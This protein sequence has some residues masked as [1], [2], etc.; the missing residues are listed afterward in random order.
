MIRIRYTHFPDGTHVRV[1]QDHHRTIVQLRAGLTRD[2]RAAAMR[3]ASWEICR[4]RT[5]KHGPVYRCSLPERLF[6]AVHLRAAALTDL[7][8]THPI[9]SVTAFG[10]TLAGIAGLVCLSMPA[11]TGP[12]AGP[13]PGYQTVTHH[14]RGRRPVA[15][16]PEVRSGWVTTY[17]HPTVETSH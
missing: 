16:Q 2:Q 8:A 15:G 13:V 5:G 9:S 12:R 14:R 4:T 3:R 11:I 17:L 6:V 1:Y 10:L 7:V